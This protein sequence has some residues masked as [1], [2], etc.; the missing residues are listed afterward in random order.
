MKHFYVSYKFTTKES[1]FENN[2]Y[3]LDYNYIL[4]NAENAEE[5]I[6]LFFDYIKDNSA[7]MIDFEN[8]YQ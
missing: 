7:N 4:V 2:G 5:A 6:D 1:D 3:G 8:L